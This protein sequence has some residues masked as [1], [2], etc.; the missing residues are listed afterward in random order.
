MCLEPLQ[1]LCS[2]VRAGLEPERLSS[3][4][5][6]R[7]MPSRWLGFTGAADLARS[8][9]KRG[10]RRPLRGP[11]LAHHSPKVTPVR[12]SP[13]VDAFTTPVKRLDMDTGAD[14]AAG[15]GVG[16]GGGCDT[17]LVLRKR[18]PRFVYDEGGEALDPYAVLDLPRSVRSWQLPPFAAISF[19]CGDLCSRPH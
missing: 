5:E 12:R 10:H 6:R 7:N 18:R 16:E 9:P 8:P 11:T 3:D 2:S 4:C 15:D 13:V 19:T 14:A 1:A 17:Q